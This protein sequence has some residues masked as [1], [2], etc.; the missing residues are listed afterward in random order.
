MPTMNNDDWVDLAAQWNAADAPDPAVLRARLR[1]YRWRNRLG[2]MSE[3]LVS[4]KE[5]IL[6]GDP[7]AYKLN[8]FKALEVKPFETA[9]TTNIQFRGATMADGELIDASA[10]VRFAQA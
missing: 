5:T 7:K 1:R 2:L 6:Y 9:T 10:F 4:T 3:L 8:I